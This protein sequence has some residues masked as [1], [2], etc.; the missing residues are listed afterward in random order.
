MSHY[1]QRPGEPDCRDFLRTGRCKY[2]DSCKYHHPIG[3]VKETDP[4]EPPFPIRP[5][6]PICQYYLKNGTCKFGQTC[7]FHHPPHLMGKSRSV[8]NNAAGASP[9]S[10]GIPVAVSNASQG[11]PRD[12]SIPG[13]FGIGLPQRPSEPDCIYFLKHAR[14]KYGATCKYHHPVTSHMTVSEAPR[15]VSYPHGLYQSSSGRE[16]SISGGSFAE[17]RESIG[18]LPRN[19]TSSQTCGP[20]DIMHESISPRSRQ[21]QLDTISHSYKYQHQPV[22]AVNINPEWHR[23]FKH[24]TPDGSPKMGSPSFTS[25]TLASSYDTAVSNIEKL[26]QASFHV[27]NVSSFLDAQCLAGIQAFCNFLIFFPFVSFER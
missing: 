13:K 12:I 24:G 3:G 4:N 23:Y 20:M 18:A 17:A 15:Y 2:G 9:S 10:S 27:Q 19:N 5:D 14:C 8:F 7:K 1:P 11:P 22:P 21:E 26:P 16:R 25:S 6:E